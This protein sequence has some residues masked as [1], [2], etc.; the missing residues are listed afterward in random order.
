[1]SAL[2]KSVISAIVR[3]CVRPSYNGITRASQAR[4]AGSTPVGRF[5]LTLLNNVDFSTEAAQI[6]N[7]S[8]VSITSATTTLAFNLF[9]ILPD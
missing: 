2:T 1:M 6:Q 7:S 5:L 9:Q 4:D 8:K 3:V